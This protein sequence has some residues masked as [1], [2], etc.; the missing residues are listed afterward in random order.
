MQP[1]KRCFISGVLA[2]A[3][4]ICGV[5]VIGETATA[6]YFYE[7]GC[8]H[9]ARVGSLLSE[10]EAA[11]PGLSVER[12]DIHTVG[13]RLLLSQLLSAYGASIGPVPM[14]FVGDVAVVG[15]TFYGLEEA[16]VELSGVA[17][18]WT[19][20]GAIEAALA[21]E[22][23]S[24]R[25]RL[26]ATA[27]E[28]VLFVEEGDP[29]GADLEL[30]AIQLLDRHPL[31][32][33][34]RMSLQDAENQRL[35]S[36]LLRLFNAR[37]DPPAF[38]VG[39]LAMAGGRLY[40]QRAAVRPFDDSPETTAYVDERVSRAVDA[41]ASSPIERFRVRERVT[42]WA[43]IGAA[44]LDS[45]NPC[46]FA[47]LVL[48]L[49]TLLVIGRRGKV[50]WAGLA[51]SAG[52]FLSYYLLGFLVYS[53][54]GITVGTRGFREPFIY[55]VSALAILVGL[56]EMK[57]LLWYG[58]W[59]SIEVPDRWKP[60]L[61]AATASVLTIPG[62]FLI[63][64]LDSLFLAPCTS[65][66]YLAILSLLSQTTERLH[67]ALLLFL[68]NLIFILPMIAI[69]LMVHFGLTTTA[70]AERWRQAK[71]TKLHFV[72]GVVMVGL[73]VGMILGVRLGFL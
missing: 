50:I 28:L 34:R 71:L 21:A 58:K 66:P 37:G 31:L 62:A 4:L 67:G 11:Y 22:A 68:Y 14:V 61:K 57:D 29:E 5:A 19:L 60:R 33:L 6:L 40:A 41:A 2:V 39:D 46:D 27:T 8:T 23:P 43:V 10:L 55:A 47:V 51:F 20:R 13:G 26:P 73:G 54:L 32:S 25:D 56:W 7:V 65:G 48:L 24:P 64:V 49:G 30:W 36:G 44:A 17:E 15:S 53:V 70:R 52:I 42:L 9:C 16:P 45:V 35:L 3:T 18:E 69:T 63:G 38:F 1:I 72:T 12:H 59:F